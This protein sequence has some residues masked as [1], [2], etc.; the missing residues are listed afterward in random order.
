M[1]K[2]PIPNHLTTHSRYFP[3]QYHTLDAQD[4]QPSILHGQGG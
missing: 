1:Y 3:E 4:D 2:E